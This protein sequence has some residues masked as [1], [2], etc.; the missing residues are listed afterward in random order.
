M[1]HILIYFD[2]EPIHVH[3]AGVVDF[4]VLSGAVKTYLCTYPHALNGLERFAVLLP[5]LTVLD[6]ALGQHDEHGLE[7]SCR[8]DLV[9]IG[10]SR[11]GTAQLNFWDEEN[12][13]RLAV[14]ARSAGYY[15]YDANG[16]RVYK[17]R[18]NFALV[19]RR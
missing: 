6:I 12:R 1:F 9:L 10:R 2:L 15:G 19:F 18:G 4:L 13:L 11:E 3:V 17:L 5:F 7:P 16:E 14:N 8:A